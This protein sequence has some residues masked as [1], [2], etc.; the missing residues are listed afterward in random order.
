MVDDDA[1]HMRASRLLTASF[2]AGAKN[3]LAQCVKQTM[4]HPHQNVVCLIT[5]SASLVTAW[6]L[7]SSYKHIYEHHLLVDF[8]ELTENH[9]NQGFGVLF[10]FIL[11]EK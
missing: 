3:V 1:L 9:T 11:Q 2:T 6:Y 10:L 8:V 7:A 5:T 4:S